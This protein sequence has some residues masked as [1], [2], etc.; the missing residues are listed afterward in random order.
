V[1]LA[2]AYYK[3]YVELDYEGAERELRTLHAKWPNDIEV[4]QSLA[5]VARR[6]GHWQESI[7]YLREARRLD[8]L[9][10]A[11]SGY[12]A[13]TLGFAHRPAEAAEVTAGLR[14]I[15]HDDAN[16]IVCEAGML[17]GLGELDRADAGLKL[18][19]ASIDASGD[20]LAERRAQYAYRRRFAEGLSWF[21][22]LRASAAV[23]DW[24]PVRRATFDL[25]TGDFHRWSGD[26]AAARQDY[27]AAVDALRD[28]ADSTHAGIDAL[29][30][31]ALA[32][33]GLGDR[34]SALRYTERL[35]ELPLSA[36]AV[37]GAVGKESLARTLARLDET[38]AAI[39]VLEHVVK[40]P[41]QMTPQRL[42]LDPDF[43]TLRADPRFEKLIAMNEQPVE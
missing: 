10:R 35:A 38:D 8:P 3:H 17:Q 22:A 33:S 15:W 14:A 20:T 30:L 7:A 9:S 34:Q 16:I 19:P 36:D 4:L 23:E 1:Q 41:S 40:E 2:R 6:L 12:L 26:A 24:D 5:L 42:R 25:A 21:E 28:D 29:R 11:N 37:N 39:A 18:V 27:Q 13:E 31:S 32:Y 43:D